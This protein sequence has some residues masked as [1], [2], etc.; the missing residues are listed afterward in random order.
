MA[1]DENVRVSVV[2]EAA[3]AGIEEFIFVTGRNKSA[4]EDHFDHSTELES[5]LIIKGKEIFKKFPGKD[6]RFLGNIC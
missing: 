3:A 4:I 1:V 2:E 5:A 6:I